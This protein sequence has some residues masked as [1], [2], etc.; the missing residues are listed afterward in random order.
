ML[1]KNFNKTLNALCI[2]TKRHSPSTHALNHFCS[3]HSSLTSA[4]R[5]E[6][7]HRL[8]PLVVVENNSRLRQLQKCKMRRQCT[9]KSNSSCK[10]T[11][12]SKCRN[13]HTFGRGRNPNLHIPYIHPLEQVG[14]MQKATA[15]LQRCEESGTVLD[16]CTWPFSKNDE[17]ERELSPPY[18][19]YAHQP[20]GQAT[21]ILSLKHKTREPPNLGIH[22]GAVAVYV[23]S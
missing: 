19:C 14:V 3:Q 1:R 20:T 18:S 10:S 21:I 8:L 6:R 23:V 5:L 15:T 4:I 7:S 16:T 13:R 2:R 22:V 17:R 12:V 11:L 9:C